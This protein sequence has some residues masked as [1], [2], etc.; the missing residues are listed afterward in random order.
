MTEKLSQQEPKIESKKDKES[1]EEVLRGLK[2][3]LDRE[4]G[5][6][7]EAM[8]LAIDDRDMVSANQTL[9]ILEKMKKKLDLL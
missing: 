8:R 5:V 6:Y 4:I 7:K 1:K 2:S 9:S 3:D